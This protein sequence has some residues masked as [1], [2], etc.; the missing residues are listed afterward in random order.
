[1]SWIG[2]NELSNSF[3]GDGYSIWLSKKQRVNS[4][5]FSVCSTPEFEAATAPTKDGGWIF[6]AWEFPNGDRVSPGD[7][8]MLSGSTALKAIWR[9][10]QHYTYLVSYSAVGGQNMPENQ[11]KVENTPLTLSDV[12]PTKI[13]YKFMGWASFFGSTIP[14]GA[15]SIYQPGDIYTLNAQVWLTAIWEANS[16]SVKY[17]ANGGEGVMENSTYACDIF[18]NLPVNMFSKD[19]HS[20]AGWAYDPDGLVAFID[21]GLIY[22]LAIADGA[23]VELYA[24]WQQNPPP[25]Y[26]VTVA[27][28][29]GFSY[30]GNYPAGATV[31]ITAT[32][33]YGNQRFKEWN[34]S[35]EA[36][37]TDGTNKTDEVAKFIM[38][39]GAVTATAIYEPIN[40]DPPPDN[41]KYIRLWGKQTKYL[42]NLFNWILCIFCFG[43]IWMA[44]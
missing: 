33:T 6:E 3:G 43:W 34:I 4:Y 39:D 17:N 21:R 38:P 2:A 15:K 28:V 42:S 18:I 11:I 12:V 20:F 26:A 19:N 25:T 40:P 7:T 14:V 31:T 35:P 27:Y 5:D 36:T 13:G 1:M 29:G 10:R 32:A 41:K 23:V 22:N 24:L 30:I 8:I 9:E 44:F 37:F 16:Y